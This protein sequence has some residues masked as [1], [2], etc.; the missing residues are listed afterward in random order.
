MVT[1]VV[2]V[3]RYGLSF[4]LDLYECFIELSL[5]KMITHHSCNL[6]LK[7][8]MVNKKVQDLKEQGAKKRL[9]VE[10]TPLGDSRD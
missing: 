7:Y 2:V 6:S 9:L 3:L 4:L 5:K 1:I 10:A 8:Y